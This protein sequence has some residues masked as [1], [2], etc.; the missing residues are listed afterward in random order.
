MIEAHSDGRADGWLARRT[1]R[2]RVEFRRQLTR[3]RTQVALGFLTLLPLLLAIAFK[4]NPNGNGSSSRQSAFGSLVDLA[5]G[6]ALN[7]A[8]F[9]LFVSSTFLLI[10][11]VAL[12]CGDTIASEASWGSLRYLLAVP[13][14]RSRLLAMKLAVALTYSAIALVLLAVSAVLV[15]LAFFGWHDLGTPLGGQLTAGEGAGR[16]LGVVG[17]LGVSLL[18]IAGL[19]FLLSVSTDAPLGA[20][21]GAVLVQI[22]A[23]ILDAV[24][25][26]GDLRN[27]LPGHYDV[28][29]L[30]LLAS[31]VQSEDMLR[32]GISSLLYFTCFVTLAWWRFLRKDVVS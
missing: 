16:F 25:A 11:V 14:P 19:A 27:V 30:G 22:V 18:P 2:Y 32:G 7:F 24:T 8:I 5:T 26:L 15:G 17:Y 23:N 9:A 4:V 3:R 6:S 10:V 13:V 21:G 12:F 31:P 29:W 28:A 20:V 1:L